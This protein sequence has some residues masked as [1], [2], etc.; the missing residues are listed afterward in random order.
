[1]DILADFI[2]IKET[3]DNNKECNL[4]ISNDFAFFDF[5][6]TMNAFLPLLLLTLT[7]VV[8]A[9]HGEET[10]NCDNIDQDLS[11]GKVI[12]IGARKQIAEAYS[13]MHGPVL[14]AEAWNGTW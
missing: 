6:P 9:V 3:I 4:M 10:L 13:Q 2:R 12:A 1:L 5:C 8:I 14:V 11:P 7:L